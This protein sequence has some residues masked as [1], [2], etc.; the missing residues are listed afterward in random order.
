MTEATADAS[1]TRSFF[2]DMLI[3]DISVEGAVLDLIDNAVDAAYQNSMSAVGSPTYFVEVVAKPDRFSIKDNCGGISVEAAQNYVFRFGRPGNYDPK[4]RIGQFGIGLKRAVFRLG[5]RFRV[6][7]STEK[8]QF[9]V[10]VDVDQW[11]EQTGDWV[12][13]MA[14]KESP[15]ATPGTTVMVDELHEGVRE[16]FSQSKYER[17]MLREIMVRYDQ[18]MAKGLHITLNGKTADMFTHQLLASSE[19][20]PEYREFELEEDGHKVQVRIVA[21]IAP[22]RR[23]A[24]ESGW[25]VYCNGRLVLEADRTALTGWGTG[26]VGGTDTPAWHTQYRRF[27][28]F[29]FFES[30]NPGALPWTTTKTEIDRSSDVYRN[31]LA[32]M[33]S[34]TRR[35]TSYTNAEK[36]EVEGFEEGDGTDP[37]PI[38]KAVGNASSKVIAEIIADARISNF[39]VPEPD[40][41]A[42]EPPGPQTTSIQFRAE[43]DRVDD[44]KD[45]LGL[46]TNRQ[47]GEAA[48]ERLY[49]AEIG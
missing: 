41:S 14:I 28:G 7:S 5:K 39:R 33:Q 2:V 38:R 44:L 19:V 32:K 49:D 4:T 23:P 42:S 8:E 15:A 20:I 47:V 43:T 3:R 26:D 45:A 13:P 31:A 6:E 40:I 17:V 34:T 22:A 30:E 35:F 25:Y 37:V 27:R 16:Q 9:A 48:F 1:A 21:G 46:K 11:R 12:F 36:N 29:V 24:A 10:D 18:M